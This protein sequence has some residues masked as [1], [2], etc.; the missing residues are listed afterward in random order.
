MVL[1]Y[2]LICG[3]KKFPKLHRFSSRL[4][5]KKD[6]VAVGKR[7]KTFR[8]FE[9]ARSCKGKLSASLEDYLEMIYRRTRSGELLKPADLAKELSVSPSAITKNVQRLACLGF[10]TYEPYGKIQ[11]TDL[12]AKTGEF[13]IQ[14][15]EIIEEFFAVLGSGEI[16]FLETEMIEHY[17]SPATVERLE[18]LTAFLRHHHRL[19]REYL[20]EK[21]L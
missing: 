18:Q 8:G 10:V 1:A 16:G 19:W 6:G 2:L 5:H 15:H 12:G 7:F 13:L 9:T 17:L 21:K 3:L 14:R 20:D 4:Y 11:L